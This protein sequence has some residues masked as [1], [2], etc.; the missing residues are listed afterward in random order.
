[1]LKGDVCHYYVDIDGQCKI[2]DTKMDDDKVW[3]NWVFDWSINLGSKNAHIE[4]NIVGFNNMNFN[5]VNNNL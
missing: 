1:M 2:D 3:S 5:K 4:S